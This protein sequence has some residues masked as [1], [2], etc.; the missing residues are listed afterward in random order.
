MYLEVA[1]EAPWE[2]LADTYLG[3]GGGA[4]RGAL[5]K[6]K[7]CLITSSIIDGSNIIDGSIIIIDESI[8]IDGSTA[9]APLPLPG[10]ARKITKGDPRQ[11]AIRL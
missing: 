5:R 2:F 8:I 9:T 3:G 11:L 7:G 6:S 4:L 1:K 10:S